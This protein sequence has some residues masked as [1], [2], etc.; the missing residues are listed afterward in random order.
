[1]FQQAFNKVFETVKFNVPNDILPTPARILDLSREDNEYTRWLDG[2]E[3]NNNVDFQL[4]AI[5]YVSGFNARNWNLSIRE[6]SFYDDHGEGRLSEELSQKI[7]NNLK[8]AFRKRI[9]EILMDYHILY[10]DDGTP[11]D[12]DDY[13]ALYWAVGYFITFPI[14]YINTYLDDHEIWELTHKFSKRVII[15][16]NSFRQ[17]KIYK[18]G[19]D[20]VN[21]RS[22][23]I[24]PVDINY[25][26][27]M[28]EVC[29]AV[30]CKDFTNYNEFD[31]ELYQLSMDENIML[32]NLIGY[33]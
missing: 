25:S 13:P 32:N 6:W 9:G 31:N 1:M 20:D 8:P 10:H 19:S 4:Q 29:A 21:G 22:D 2:W 26:F 14:V 18:L 24:V 23:L 11:Y 30:L 5:S 15:T 28:L 33:L 12:L 3:E 27:A 16:R 7:S 17:I